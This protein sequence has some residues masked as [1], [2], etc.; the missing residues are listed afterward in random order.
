MHERD[1]RRCFPSTSHTK[2]ATLRGIQRGS[3]FLLGM[4]FGFF[5]VFFLVFWAWMVENV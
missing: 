5:W 2:L 4:F 1:K 3:R